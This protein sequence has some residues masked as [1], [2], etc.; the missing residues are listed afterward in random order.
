MAVL[1]SAALSQ[2]CPVSLAPWQHL[3][4][5]VINSDLWHSEKDSMRQRGGERDGKKEEGTKPAQD[6]SPK[7]QEE[8][9]ALDSDATNK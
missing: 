5:S 3:L 7:T 8:A 4:Q 9:M 1:I 6:F 2:P